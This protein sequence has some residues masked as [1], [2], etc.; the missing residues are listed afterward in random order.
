MPASEAFAYALLR[1]IPD[2]ERGECLNAGVVLF[3]R[4]HRFLEARAV[5][6]EVRLHALSPALDARAVR[7]HLR[8]L[9]LIAAGDPA[10]GPV[11]GQEPSERFHWLCA[12]AST[13][14]QPSAVHTGLTDDPAGTLTRL[15]ERLVR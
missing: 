12:P 1:V 5:L 7:A 13:I 4:R 9:E 2:V 6:D 8:A 3:S 10:G 11:A 15:V 14:V